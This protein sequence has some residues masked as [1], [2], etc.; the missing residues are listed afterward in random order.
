M[1]E[2]FPNETD[3]YKARKLMSQQTYASY[4]RFIKDEISQRTRQSTVRL[5]P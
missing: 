2:L 4:M 5:F 1:A 3:K